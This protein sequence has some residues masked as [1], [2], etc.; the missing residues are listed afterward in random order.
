MGD[1]P[2]IARSTAG[3]ATLG[4]IVFALLLGPAAVHARKPTRRIASITAVVF[5]FA[6]HSPRIAGMPGVTSFASSV[7]SQF[8]SRMQPCELVL[9]IADGTGVPW[10]P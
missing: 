7:A 6:S 1:A 4:A 9:P 3:V 10:I 5:T 2:P 8:V